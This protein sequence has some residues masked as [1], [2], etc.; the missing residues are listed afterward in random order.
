MKIALIVIGRLENRYVIEFIDYYKQLGI[1]TIFIVDN[2]NDDEE[3]FE[4]VLSDEYRQ[5]NSI[6]II[7]YR[8]YQD[9][10]NFQID[11]Y[12]KIY[13]KF[14]DKFDWFIFLDFDEFLTLTEDKTIQDYLSRECFKNKIQILINWKIYTDNDLVYDDGRGCLE[15]FVTPMDIYKHVEYKDMFENAHVKPLIRTKIT[16]IKFNNP[17]IINSSNKQLND[18][19]NVTSCNNCGNLCK[20]H[21]WQLD[22]NNLINYDLSYIKHFTTK[23]IDE[24][25]NNKIK[26]G[27]GD[28]KPE[29]FNKTYPLERF[30]KYNKIT[31]EKLKYLNDQGFDITNLNEDKCKQWYVE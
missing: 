22:S 27:C 6:K 1:N 24:W 19:L 9:I 8:G 30:F 23:T 11:T 21:H 5:K 2:N 26:R 12:V 20:L 28:R 4:D 7:H 13:N 10:L 31:D 3:W 14:K 25:V 17:H 29:F 15:R 18:I 16:N